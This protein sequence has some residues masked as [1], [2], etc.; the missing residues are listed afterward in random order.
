M[1]A[2]KVYHIHSYVYQVTAVLTNISLNCRFL[3]AKPNRENVIPKSLLFSL[4]RLLRPRHNRL[5]RLL[6]EK[7]RE[8]EE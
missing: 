1:I 5:P 4:R 3:L 8:F 6:S 7:D 2:I